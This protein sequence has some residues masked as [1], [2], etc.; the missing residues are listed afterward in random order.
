MEVLVPGDREPGPGD[1]GSRARP[2]KAAPAEPA[3]YPI[4][5]RYARC[6]TAQQDLRSRLDALARAKCKRIF[7][8]KINTRAK[9]RPKLEE[10]LKPA[11]PN[12][13]RRG[14]AAGAGPA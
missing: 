14:G 8:E 9:T 6:S 4:R 5:I 13:R 7:S 2:V 12:E 1:R 11:C 3:A 10:V